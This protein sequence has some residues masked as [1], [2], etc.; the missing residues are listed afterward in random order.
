MRVDKNEVMISF[1]FTGTLKNQYIL[2]ICVIDVSCVLVIRTRKNERLVL[3]VLYPLLRE[4]IFW[5][6]L[7]NLGSNLT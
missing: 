6:F 7:G 4:D 5:C 1:N 3:V 2:V